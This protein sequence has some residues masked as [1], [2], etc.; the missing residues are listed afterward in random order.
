[1]QLETIIN[2]CQEYFA[3][4]YSQFGHMVGSTFS[5]SDIEEYKGYAKQ[6]LQDNQI[7]ADEKEYKN[8]D[9]LVERLYLENCQYGLAT[10]IVNNED[11][12]IEELQINRWNDVKY[13]NCYGEII[14]IYDCFLS[15][16]HALNI[17]TKLL[18]D[19][20]AMWD[21][22]SPI[23][24]A[25]LGKGRRVTAIGFDCLDPDAGVALTLRIV[26]GRKLTKDDLIENGT[27]NEKIWK[28]HCILT[29]YGTSMI[30]GGAPNSGKTTYAHIM[31]YEAI[32]NYKR[33]HT[34]ELEIREVDTVKYDENGRVINNSINFK[35]RPDPDPDYNIG[36]KEL[37]VMEMTMN[38]QHLFLVETKDEEAKYVVQI[39]NTGT[40][41]VT[42]TH[43]SSALDIVD[44]FIDLVNPPDV[45]RFM[46]KLVK[47]FPI[48]NF[49]MLLDDQKT[50]RIMEIIEPVL[51]RKDGILKV[52]ARILWQ[53]VVKKY[54]YDENGKPIDVIGEYKKVNNISEELQ[55]MLMI[56][57]CTEEELK[58]IMS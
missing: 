32:P 29:K 40:T 30:F 49:Q 53:Y 43:A 57:G 18:R 26:N 54:I 55:H 47:G 10:P 38:P 22:R 11:G 13:K 50:R 56:H 28:L 23:K 19:N 34:M 5:P 44:R 20:K 36:F 17:V 41:V 24:V 21:V 16:E 3:N 14:P 35:T 31:Q 7:T 58:T 52:E 25:P 46:Q 6:W 15:P 37:S 9:A 4:H 8:Q 12:T 33:W 48:L 27:V 2:D 51:V 42:S 45:E 1:M 39:A